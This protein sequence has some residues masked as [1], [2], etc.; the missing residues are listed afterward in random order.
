MNLSAGAT[1]WTNVLST[2]DND[3]VKVQVPPAQSLY[4][5]RPS[6]DA[7]L[8][9]PDSSG[10]L[11]VVPNQGNRLNPADRYFSNRTSLPITAYVRL[12]SSGRTCPFGR[13]ASGA[14]YVTA[15]VGAT[16]LTIPSATGLAP[17]TATVRI[18]RAVAVPTVVLLSTRLSRVA[19]W[20]SKV[21][22]PAN[23]TSASFTV[24]PLTAG[25]VL[26]DAYVP[27]SDWLYSYGDSF[28]YTTSSATF[29][30]L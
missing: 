29:T 3:W 25:S 30:S 2:A 22:I 8:Y 15:N 16:I 14:A 4:F 24:T 20:P 1:L 17:V 7:T 11:A 26:I 27:K 13:W 10:K 12:S 28:P 18:E 19:T 5:S 21:V 23:T 6:C 9:L